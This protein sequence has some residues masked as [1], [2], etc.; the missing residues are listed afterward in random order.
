MATI[1]LKL[2]AG[3]I[4]RSGKRQLPDYFADTAENCLLLSGELRGLHVP[5]IL[6]QFDG[7][8]PVARAFRVPDEISP[9]GFLWI[10]FE[11]PNTDFLKGPLVND[12]YDRYYWSCGCH[13]PKYASLDMLRNNDPGYYLGVDRPT[14]ALTVVPTTGTG[15]TITRAYVYTFVSEFGEE[16]PPS[17]PTLADGQEDSTWQLSNFET[18][19]PNA[20]QKSITHKRI[21]RTVTGTSGVADYFFVAEIPIADIIY[22][23]TESTVDVALNSLL[24]SS[25]WFPPPEGLQGL[26][27]HP[28]GF[29]VGFVGR[30][31]YFSEPY[32]P[33][34]WPP[35]YVVSTEFDIVGL[36]VF[37][38]SI[39]VTTDGHPYS[40]TG[41]HP[42]SSTFI[43]AATPEPCLSKRGIV[44]MPFGV[45]Y[46]SPNGLILISPGGVKNATQ[47]I[48]T[49]DE[50][51]TLSPETISAT[52]YNTQYLAFTS[53]TQGWMFAPDEPEASFVSLGKVWQVT[54]I[55]AD[56]YT[57]T[58]FMLYD[59][60]VSEWNPAGGFPVSFTWKSKKFV[61][62]KPLNFAAFRIYYD[63]RD[64]LDEDL[65]LDI[66]AFNDLRIQYPL[67][68]LGY[69]TFGGVRKLDID[70]SVPQNK[71]PLGG[72]PLIDAEKLLA[73]TGW[74]RL[75]VYANDVLVYDQ[76][77]LDTHPHTLPHGFKADTW[78]FQ[79]EGTVNVGQAK[80][81]ESGKELAEI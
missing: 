24:E 80:F 64:D 32:R 46:P 21:Y 8:C 7:A 9:G 75:K 51:A 62:P 55:Q 33:H 57:G 39:A 61:L 45:Y 66:L 74:V 13:V 37:G 29:L 69:N 77:V 25:G 17:D 16:G 41:V 73:E 30:D 53:E 40:S 15:D 27:A 10:G 63:L 60:V 49:K 50:W 52:R 72:S 23:D 18:S 81:A 71:S 43:K 68:P 22:A 78:Q 12:L 79:L 14:T 59:D 67:N 11:D 47:P 38:T 5:I 42:A 31:L 28:N 20:S 44:S 70:T 6:H 65:A 19:V 4:P 26:V 34:A 36:G 1:D 48:L 35:E 76:P 54:D 2:F 3:E 56:P 58:V